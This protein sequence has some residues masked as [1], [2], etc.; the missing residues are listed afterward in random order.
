[1]KLV[2]KL[3]ARGYC[4]FMKKDD[5]CFK[6]LLGIIKPF[7]GKKNKVMRE[8]ISTEERLVVTLRYIAVGRS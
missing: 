1:M 5:N 3:E 2:K 8:F 6:E 7:I 4:H